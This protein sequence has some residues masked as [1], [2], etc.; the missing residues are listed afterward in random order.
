M[1]VHILDTDTVESYIFLLMPPHVAKSPHKLLRYFTHCGNRVISDATTHTVAFRNLNPNSPLCTKHYLARN[2]QS[3]LPTHCKSTILY[4]HICLTPTDIAMYVLKNIFAQFLSFASLL[5]CITCLLTTKCSL[6]F[7]RN[8]LSLSWMCCD[9]HAVCS[10]WLI[11][12]FIKALL[13]QI[14]I[15]FLLLSFSSLAALPSPYF[16][17][18]PSLPPSSF[19][20]PRFLSNLLT[21]SVFPPSL[22]DCLACLHALLS[23]GFPSTLP[24]VLI[25]GGN[26]PAPWRSTA[27]CIES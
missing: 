24:A 21:Y 3:A 4:L 10:F 16:P 26:H 20:S 12:A 9:A 23:S 27:W 1:Y 17:S 6:T 11:C 22:P 13:P 14:P 15:E 19:P 5:K 8:V 2:I 7:D 18:L 25:S